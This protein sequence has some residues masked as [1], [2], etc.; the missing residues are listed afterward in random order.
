MPDD[1]NPNDPHSMNVDRDPAG[2]LWS[3]T[4]TINPFVL[5]SS[6]VSP[7]PTGIFVGIDLLEQDH[8]RLT[9]NRPA[10]LYPFFAPRPGGVYSIQFRHYQG[11]LL[12]TYGRSRV[13]RY[14]FI[15][16]DASCDNTMATWDCSRTVFLDIAGIFIRGGLERRLDPPAFYVKREG[17]GLRT[18][19]LIEIR[20]QQHEGTVY[21]SIPVMGR[22][23]LN[24]TQETLAA[25]TRR[26]NIRPEGPSLED[27]FFSRTETRENPARENP[28]D[29]P[30]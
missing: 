2:Y 8:R 23:Q 5:P 15:I 13:L 1:R 6:W 16:S 18:R 29:I 22:T 14:R 17:E 11:E 24:N 28:D 30:F 12:R 25:R 26:P 10:V 27:E 3:T 4:T 20:G 21:N 19:Y 9:G 7:A